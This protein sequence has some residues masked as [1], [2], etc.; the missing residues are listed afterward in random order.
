MQCWSLFVQWNLQYLFSKWRT[1]S[2]SWRRSM[3]KN[4]TIG[5]WI[6]FNSINRS[7]GNFEDRWLFF[8][9]LLELIQIG[10]K[11]QNWRRSFI[12]SNFTVKGNRF[13]CVCLNCGF[14]QTWESNCR[15]W[16]FQRMSNRHFLND[17][18]GSSRVG[19]RFFVSKNHLSIGVE[20]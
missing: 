10:L 8:P 12:Y 13:E 15:S 14:T 4:R 5:I 11:E 6:T 9:F 19:Y 18:M 17:S 20:H 2:N 1:I 16:V 7:I 3:M